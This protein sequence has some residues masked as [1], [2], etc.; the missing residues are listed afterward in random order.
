MSRRVRRWPQSRAS[1]RLPCIECGAPRACWSVARMRL[2]PSS[3]VPSCGGSCRCIPESTRNDDEWSNSQDIGVSEGV[4]FGPVGAWEPSGLCLEYGKKS[5]REA[6]K[7]GTLS[8][9]EKPVRKS[10]ST[11]QREEQRLRIK[12]SA[13]CRHMDSPQQHGRRRLV[14]DALDVVQEAIAQQRPHSLGES[15]HDVHQGPAASYAA[16]TLPQIDA[17]APRLF[18]DARDCSVAEMKNKQQAQGRP[19]KCVFCARPAGL[20]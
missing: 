19:I 9:R 16:P 15:S 5:R 7:T 6:E 1:E 8:E 3:P 13:S 10:S 2:R 18:V 12:T 20:F 14:D 4:F 17:N 11:R